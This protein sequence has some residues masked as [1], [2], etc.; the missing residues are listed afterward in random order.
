[1]MPDKETMMWE[2]FYNLT[3]LTQAVHVLRLARIE[4][5]RWSAEHSAALVLWQE[6]NQTLIGALEDARHERDNADYVVRT[7]AEE[8]YKLGLSQGQQ[9]PAPGVEIKLRAVVEYDQQEALHWA[10]TK[11]LCLLLDVKAFESIARTGVIPFAEIVHQ[12]VAYIARDLGKALEGSGV[13]D[14]P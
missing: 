5:E 13:E 8:G 10:K 6:E 9:H 2:A 11:D 3:P 1:M 7:M 12:P 4:H 14:G